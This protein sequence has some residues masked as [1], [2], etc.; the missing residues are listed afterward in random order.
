MFLCRTG[1]Y[2]AMVMIYGD[3]FAVPI[4]GE[5]DSGQVSP[6]ELSKLFRNARRLSRFGRGADGSFVHDCSEVDI[7]GLLVYK[8]DQDRLI[9]INDT[10]LTTAACDSQPRRRPD[11]LPVRVVGQAC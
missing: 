2:N 7:D 6:R 3:E 10:F 11:Q 5:F 9:E 1:R 4:G 8:I